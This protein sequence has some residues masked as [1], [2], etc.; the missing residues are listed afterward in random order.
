[1]DGSK[2]RNMEEFAAASGISRPTVS[3]YF[4]DPSSVRQSTR[5]RIEEALER[6][7]FRPNIFAM[8]Q[9]RRLTKNIGIVVPYLADPFFAEIARNIERRCIDAGFWPILF[10]A[11]GERK[12]ENDILDSLRSLRPAGVLLAPLGRAS[13]RAAVEK[14]CDDVPTILFDSNIDGVGRAFI[15]S[16]NFQFVSLMVDYL[17][18][19]GEPPCFFE[20]RTPANPNANKRRNGYIQA[21][22]RLGH[23]PQI[24]RAEGEGW[25][26]E[27]VGYREGLRAIEERLLPTNT[28]LCSNDRLAIGFLAACYEKGLRV[29]RGSG[30]ALRVAGHDDHPFSRFTCPPLTTVAQ[31]YEAISNRS[32][33]AL[34]AL[35]QNGTPQGDRLEVLFEGKL[36][37]RASA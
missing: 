31:N 10:S 6:Y 24:I 11:H 16:D 22:E 5:D 13:D 27:E 30:S 36:V 29:G 7:D 26:F 35:I 32:V 21:M 18:R 14:F 4:N 9:N 28:V 19:T 17:C 20:M 1:M 3:K 8:N 2:I 37:M 15:G 33:E 34:F 25:G 12:L 23:A